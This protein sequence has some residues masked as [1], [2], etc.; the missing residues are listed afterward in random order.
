MAMV[1]TLGL[2]LIA[3]LFAI[4]GAAFDSGLEQVVQK[5]RQGI[6]DNGAEAVLHAELHFQDFIRNHGK[7]YANSQEYAHRLSIFRSNLLKALEHQALDPTATHGIT[8]FSDLSEEEFEAQYMGLRAPSYMTNGSPAPTLPVDNLPANFDWREL[9][10]VSEVKNQGSCG[11]CWAFSTTG[12][13]EGAHKIS[14]GKLLSLS[15]QQLVDCDHTCDPVDKYACN[16]GCNGGLM[17]SAYEYVIQAGG[18]ELESE[19]P[20]TG[21]AGKCQFSSNKVAAQVASFTTISLDEDQIAANL[22]KNGPLAVG[23]N[24]AFMQTYIG[25]VSCPLICS[26][27]RI[28]HGVLIVGYAEK[29]FAPLRLT[30]KPYWIIKNSWG[31]NWGEDGYYKICRGIGSCGVNTMVSAVAAKV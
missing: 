9:G 18:L 31:A 12:A 29:G 30:N 5:Q 28:D 26:K 20:Y 23:I 25:G 3:A 8:Q 14:T 2:V 11:S 27:N 15:E 17:T 7:S 4:A 22:V 21:I 1:G 13:V 19:Y 24:A 10:A 16:A 6:L